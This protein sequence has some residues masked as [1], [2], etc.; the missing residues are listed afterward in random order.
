MPRPCLSPAMPCCLEF[1]MCLPFGLNSAV[2]S[3]SHLPWRARAMLWPCSSSQG[4]GT[5]DGRLSTVMLCCGLEKNGMVRA[6]PEHGMVSVNQT[7][8]HCVN[9]MG[10]THSKPL[11]ALHGRVTAC[12]VWIGINKALHRW[13][14]NG[15]RQELSTWNGTGCCLSA[16]STSRRLPISE[17]G[18][19]GSMAEMRTG[20]A[21]GT[22]RLEEL[23][24]KQDLPC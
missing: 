21:N 14:R 12:Y 6:W 23:L 9:Q 16:M 8:P 24:I 1:R 22:H 15:G 7:R 19:L 2:V 3:D 17:G 18:M 11:A 5:A 20:R 4:H 10:M 13:W